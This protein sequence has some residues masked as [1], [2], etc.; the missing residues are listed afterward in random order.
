LKQWV[1]AISVVEVRP[2]TELYAKWLKRR[3]CSKNRYFL[4]TVISRA[5]KK[6]KIW[7][8]FELRKFSLDLAFNIRGQRREQ[9]LFFI[10]AQ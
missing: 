7:Q 8:T 6:V 10:G 3:V 4:H 1:R 2:R 5:P 9:L